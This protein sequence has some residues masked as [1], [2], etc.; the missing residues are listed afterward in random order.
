[1]LLLLCIF[2]GNECVHENEVTQVSESLS[3][4]DFFIS[5][6]RNNFQDNIES[7]DG[8]YKLTGCRKGYV[9]PLHDHVLISVL[10]KE[11]KFSKLPPDAATGILSMSGKKPMV[12]KVLYAQHCM[13]I[14]D[15]ISCSMQAEPTIY[16]CFKSMSAVSCNRA[17]HALVST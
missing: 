4:C 15:L 16:N 2:Q 1:M 13:H 12:R 3:G 9:D 11:Q 10:Y 8:L 6:S 14:T 5:E 7:A 17:P